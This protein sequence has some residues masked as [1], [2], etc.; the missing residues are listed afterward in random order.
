MDVNELTKSMQ[1]IENYLLRVKA[2]M[3]EA[4]ADC[5]G[6]GC[7]GEDE[8]DEESDEGAAEDEE[9]EEDDAEAEED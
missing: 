6:E 3:M 4:A 8:E 9:E 1:K 2:D 7:D 5:V